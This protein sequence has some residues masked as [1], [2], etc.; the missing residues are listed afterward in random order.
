[1]VAVAAADHKAVVAPRAAVAAKVVALAPA[2]A[3]EDKDRG[4]QAAGQ[5]PQE[6]YQGVDEAMPRL[7][8][9]RSK[10]NSLQRT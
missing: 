1:M 6:T 7:A 8:V 9:A 5:A 4:M 10:L 3:D 2:A